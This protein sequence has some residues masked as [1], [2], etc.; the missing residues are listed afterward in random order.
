MAYD[1]I[2][3][4]VE[5]IKRRTKGTSGLSRA[6]AELSKEQ[7]LRLI[8]LARDDEGAERKGYLEGAVR[9]LEDAYH[10]HPDPELA[11]LLSDT[12]KRL[13]DVKQD[14]N[15][16]GYEFDYSKS[17]LYSKL[18]KNKVISRGKRTERIRRISEQERN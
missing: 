14:L 6:I 16:P 5:D 7:A 8:E 9:Q 10:N 1:T 17:S 3:P 4:N 13:G 12:Y 2:K 11:S 18:A 15:M